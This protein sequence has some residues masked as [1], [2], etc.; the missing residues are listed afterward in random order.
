MF[1]GDKSKYSWGNRIK[2]QGKNLSLGKIFFPGFELIGLPF[3]T[4]VSSLNINCVG[5]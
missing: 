1:L 2:I 4:H 3:L 5:P